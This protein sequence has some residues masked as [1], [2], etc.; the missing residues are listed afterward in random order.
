MET[1]RSHPPRYDL[2]DV[3]EKLKFSQIPIWLWYRIRG[4]KLS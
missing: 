1:S 4:K 2:D 3:I